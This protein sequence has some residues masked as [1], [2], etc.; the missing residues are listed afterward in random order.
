MRIVQFIYSLYLLILWFLFMPFAVL[1]FIINKIF[2]PYKNQIKWVY[3]INAAYMSAWE[4]LVGIRLKFY[5]LETLDT[6]KTYI[7]IANHNNVADIVGIAHGCKVPAK[8]LF[9]KEISKIPFLGWLF[10]LSAIPVDRTSEKGRKESLERMRNELAMGVSIFIFPEGTRNRT[11][12]PLK[13]F[14]HGAFT[15]AIEA[16]T[17]ILPMVLIGMRKISKPT[18]LLFRPGTIHVHYLEPIPTEGLTLADMD[19]LRQKCFDI[20]Q[21]YIIAHDDYFEH[22]KK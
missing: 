22:L 1:A 8:P 18:S 14:H 15:L 2:V 20:I 21:S 5:N 19:S 4:F 16:Q 7:V 3:K 9:K 10:S 12:D 17:P 11:E 6:N 13:K